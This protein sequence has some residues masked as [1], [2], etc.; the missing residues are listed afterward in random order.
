MR[1]SNLK[2]H[3]KLLPRS[4]IRPFQGARNVFARRQVYRHLGQRVAHRDWLDMSNK[5]APRTIRNE[6]KRFVGQQFKR[7]VFDTVRNDFVNSLRIAAAR[8]K[9]IDDQHM[10]PILQEGNRLSREGANRVAAILIPRGHNFDHRH[11]AAIGMANHDSI[12]FLRVPR[13]IR[14]GRKSGYWRRRLQ[15]DAAIGTFTFRY[16]GRS[17]VECDHVR[18]RAARFLFDHGEVT[19]RQT[20]S[21]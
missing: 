3:G 19:I 14:P 18:F 20:T 4:K 6:R 21:V 15:G 7:L 16:R 10:D 8:R 1:Y 2:R 12:G 5:F 9:Q 11:E 13:R 17:Q